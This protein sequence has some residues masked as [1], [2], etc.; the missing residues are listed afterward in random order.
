[1]VVEIV[2]SNKIKFNTKQ[3]RIL[4][5]TPLKNPLLCIKDINKMYIALLSKLN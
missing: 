1:M 3:N 2:K 5:K 4:R